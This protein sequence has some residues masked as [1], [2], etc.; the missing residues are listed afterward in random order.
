LDYP[1]IIAFI[2]YQAMLRY[3]LEPP[4]ELEELV[5]P[6]MALFDPSQTVA[7]NP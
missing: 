1:A 5:N 4:R 6:V 3:G 7:V 2:P